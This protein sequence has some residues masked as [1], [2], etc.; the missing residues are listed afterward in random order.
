MPDSLGYLSAHV[1]KILDFF[2]SYAGE[3]SENV[4]FVGFKKEI[5][6]A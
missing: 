6:L 2:P 5:I 4:G 1:G 3:L